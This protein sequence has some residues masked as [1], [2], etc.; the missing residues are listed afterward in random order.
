[1]IP[2]KFQGEV[3]YLKQNPLHGPKKISLRT[4]IFAI[5]DDFLV[6]W[7]ETW[8]LPHFSRGSRKSSFFY[9]YLA[10]GTFRNRKYETTLVFFKSEKWTLFPN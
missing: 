2:V 1:M 3:M 7:M 4:S 5:F 8:T 9:G 10:M 6:F